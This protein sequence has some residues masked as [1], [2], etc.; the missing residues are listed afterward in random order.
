ML[1]NYLIRGSAAFAVFLVLVCVK[2]V[3]LQH[4]HFSRAEQYYRASDWKSAIREYDET[5]HAY[6]PWSPY[7][8]RSAERLWQMGE[9][10]E[11]QGKLEWANKSY[12]T[13]RSSFY[14]SRSL[15]TPGREWIRKCDDRIADLNVRI[16]IRD[17]SLKPEEAGL[18]KQ[19][20]LHVLT[21]DRAPAPGWAV[22]VEA[23]FFGWIASTV[24]I[25]LR[26]FD[27]SGK[28]RRK[29]VFYGAL[30]FIFTFALW[31]IGMLKA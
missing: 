31:V 21:V 1:K 13:I 30:S 2:V 9:M 25:A 6:T 22:A 27:D 18:E 14:A 19:K 28:I 11:N 26:G 16:L 8:T 15:Y 4:E 3:Y 29:P 12:A 23:G 7:I 17:G 24:F 5:M 10:F 20:Q